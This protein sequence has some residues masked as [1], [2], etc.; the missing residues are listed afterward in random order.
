MLAAMLAAM[1]T[2]T[3]AAMLTVPPGRNRLARRAA[4]H[5]PAAFA[6]AG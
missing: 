6:P 4:G 2:V 3:L 5:A 1:L